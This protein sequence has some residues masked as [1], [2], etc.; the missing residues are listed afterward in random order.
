MKEFK[1]KNRS[2]ADIVVEE[3]KIVIVP[4]RISLNELLAEVTEDNR[5]IMSPTSTKIQLMHSLYGFNA[6]SILKLFVS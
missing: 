3:G 6:P 2:P 4:K 1:I 5:H